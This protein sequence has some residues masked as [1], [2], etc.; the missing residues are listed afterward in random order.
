[1]FKLFSLLLLIH[2]NFSSLLAQDKEFER[3]KFLTSKVT[4][5]STYVLNVIKLGGLYKNS[6][7]DSA[8]F[9]AEKGFSVSSKI[10]F[11]RG[12][13]L[14]LN[15]E[16]VLFMKLGNYA[17]G[18]QYFLKALEICD[19]HDIKK[20][21]SLVLINIGD[22]YSKQYDLRKALDY[23]FQAKKISESIDDTLNL[24]AIYIN[25]GSYYE[26]LNLFDSARINTEMGR[27]LAEKIT[28][29][30]KIEIAH[31]Y[32]GSAL[33][34]LG[35]INLKTK[36][37]VL[38]L[39]YYRMSLGYFLD[40]EDY[41]GLC[42]SYLGLAKVFDSIGNRDSSF[43]YAKRSLSI[44]TNQKFTKYVFDASEYVTEYYKKVNQF[45]SAFAYQQTM[46]AAKD[47]LFSQDK[48][49]Q[50]QILTIN[51]TLRQN[52]LA[53][54]KLRAEEERKINLQYIAIAVF[55]FIFS[56]V[57]ILIIR[58]RIRLTTINFMVT[59]ALLL[60]FEYISLLIHPTISFWTHHSPVYMLLV[61]V[62]VAF[63]LVPLHHRLEHWI[64]ETLSHK[65]IHPRTRKVKFHS[66]KDNEE[67]V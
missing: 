67:N 47:S 65:I 5:D 60:I 44:A 52:E 30:Q 19:K 26:S 61:L 51:E 48:V 17:K 8:L 49:K 18:L 12:E 3:L 34:S 28:N 64:K 41:E 27:S 20:T 33:N 9:L 2:L 6:D 21:A 57:I 54:E 16:G 45:D 39:E 1:M 42:D 11:I 14:S 53:V 56:L 32:I 13:V 25:I 55:I 23:V 35:H 36:H 50:L 46:I 7:V 37:Y 66:S 15:L 38:S 4:Y 43:Y 31:N 10:N 62:G 29:P 58:Q 63:I 40:T 59:V 24:T 22:L